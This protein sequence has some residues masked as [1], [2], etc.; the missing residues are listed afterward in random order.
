LNRSGFAGGC[1][2]G[3]VAE[4]VIGDWL[5]FYNTERPHSSLGGRTSA[6]SYAGARPVDKWTTGCAGLTT[7]PQA[8]QQLQ[9]SIKMKK[10]L[11]A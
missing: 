10:N 9:N 1:S 4:R 5:V 3:F 7:Y 8:Q 6:E 11:T 2:D